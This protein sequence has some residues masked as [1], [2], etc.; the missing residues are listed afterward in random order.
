MLCVASVFTCLVFLLH[1]KM[2]YVRVEGG[3][4]IGVLALIKCYTF[5]CFGDGYFRLFWEVM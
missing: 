4:L 3:A 5:S 2:L 1:V